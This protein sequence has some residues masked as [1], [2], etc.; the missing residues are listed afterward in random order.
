M[1]DDD[2]SFIAG[3]LIAATI[4]TITRFIVLGAVT[5]RWEK[6]TVKHGAAEYVMDHA[7][8]KTTWQWKESK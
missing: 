6:D 3:F 2:R 1:N 8:G 5:K 7:T 4:V